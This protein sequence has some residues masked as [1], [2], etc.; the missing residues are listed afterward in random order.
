LRILFLMQETAPIER[1]GIMYLSAALK[2]KGHKVFLLINKGHNIKPLKIKIHDYQPE[3]IAYSV[4]TG[5]HLQALAVNKLLKA[6]FKYI[7]VFGG[8]HATFYPELIEEKGVD[9][10]CLG[11]GDIAFPEFCRLF[12]DRYDYWKAPNF[13]VKHGGKVY[14]N[15]LLPLV[16]NLDDLP[17]PDREI[18]YQADPSLMKDGF[19]LF[20]AS[21]GC[22]YQCSYCFNSSYNKLYQGKGAVVRH[23]SPENLISEICLVKSKYNVKTVYVD[24]DVFLI[25][26]AGWIEKFCDLYENK[27]KLPLTCHVRADLVH[28]S[29]IKR[30]KSIGLTAVWMG[31]EC[32]DEFLSNKVLKR[33]LSNKQII[34]AARIIQKNN[35]KLCTQNLMGLP[36]EKSFL[37]DLKT[38]DL[39]IT[40]KPDFGW[41]SILYPYPGTEIASYAQQNGFFSSSNKDFLE[42]N[43]R[44]SIFNFNNKFEKRR[45]ENLHKLFGFFVRFPVLRKYTDSLCVLPLT[46]FYR[47]LYYLWYG[48]NVKIKLYPN[49]SVEN[50][51]W[52][53]IVLL[54]RFVRKS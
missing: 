42:T 19:K 50:E 26:P 22:P 13:I 12:E 35:V 31:V 11:E 17:F 46:N 1:I 28:D 5:E 25:K 32:G 51:F 16:K 37:N 18:I 7:S 39:N 53:Y 4:M 44:S 41:S 30:L 6:E 45:I 33:N 34:D 15:D 8:P 29:V 27:I 36:V 52:K 23:R 49:T 47:F 14:R 54:I 43:K 2:K 38:L 48:Y 20:F 40:I 21:R 9:A 10:V 3:I 24:D